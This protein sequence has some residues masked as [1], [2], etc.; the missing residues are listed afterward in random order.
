MPELGN[1]LRG[2]FHAVIREMEP[3]VFRAEY[4]GELNPD[5]PDARAFPDY[6]LGTSFED[7]KIW[8]EQ[9][10]RTMGYARVVWDSLPENMNE[11]RA[12]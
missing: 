4:R 10:A 9:M 1:P 3:G 7:V 12:T 2:E 11:R 5:N 6:H 8:V